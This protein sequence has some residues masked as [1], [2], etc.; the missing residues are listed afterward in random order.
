[1]R[2]WSAHREAP[3]PPR[4]AEEAAAHQELLADAADYDL[5]LEQ[6]EAWYER[7]ALEEEVKLALAV[8]A[9][10][11]NELIALKE[12]SVVRVRA[13]EGQCV[14]LEDVGPNTQVKACKETIV[15]GKLFGPLIDPKPYAKTVM[16]PAVETASIVICSDGVWDALLA[17]AVDGIA[18][19]GL[20]NPAQNTAEVIVQRALSQRH[21]YSSVG[22][23]LPKDDT[24]CI[25]ILVENDKD[26]STMSMSSA[27]SCCSC[28]SRW[29]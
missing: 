26:S 18:R 19:G 13:S 1:M 12:L 15:K 17:S 5:L 22:D 16:L 14:V 2:R 28:K 11:I 10:R 9:Q 23:Q 24:T 3:P 7:K 20:A 25:V 29:G 21:A 27:S 4:T 6:V 8:E